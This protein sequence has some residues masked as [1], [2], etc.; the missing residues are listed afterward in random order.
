MI[1][2]VF[3]MLTDPISSPVMSVKLG[4]DRDFTRFLHDPT[5]PHKVTVCIGEEQLN[6]SGVVLAQQSSVLERK[7]REDNGVLMFEEFLDVP[8][9]CTVSLFRCI[10]Y[11]HGADLEFDVETLAVV[12]KFASLYEVEDLFEQSLIWLANHLNAT[13]SVRSALHSLRIA[14][15]LSGERS[16]RIERI[17][18]QFIKLN[19][20]LFEDGFEDLLE[21]KITGDGMILIAN[22]KPNNIGSLLMKWIALSNEN[23]T[24]IMENLSKVNFTEIFSSAEDFSLFVALLS[25][26]AKSADSIK[27]LIDLQKSFF[28]CQ[29]SNQKQQEKEASDNEKGSETYFDK[30]EDDDYVDDDYEEG[31][32]DEDDYEEYDDEEYDYDED[33]YEEEDYDDDVYDGEAYDEQDYDEEAYDQQ[34]YGYDEEDYENGEDDYDQEEYDKEAEIH[35]VEEELDCVEQRSSGHQINEFKDKES[36]KINSEELSKLM[37]SSLKEFFDQ[38]PDVGIACP[39]FDVTR[40]YEPVANPVTVVSRPSSRVS[41]S[42]RGN[43]NTRGRGRLKRRRGSSNEQG[44]RGGSSCME[45]GRSRGSGTGKESVSGRGRGSGNE[46]GRGR[47][48]SKEGSRGRGSGK[49]SGRGRGSSKEGSRGRGSGKESGRGRGSGTEG[50]RGSGKEGSR[51]RGS[52]KDSGRGRG[53]GK[54]SGRG[55]GS[56]KE[57]GRGRGSGTEGGRGRGSGSGKESGSSPGR[58]T[59]R[60][61]GKDS[62]SSRG[63]GAGRGSSSA[64]GR[65]SSG[66]GRGSS[67]GNNVNRGRGGS[68]GS[69]GSGRGGSSK[70]G[71]GK[72]K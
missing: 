25:A 16:S 43:V 54:E 56:G 38:Q 2:H 3:T 45:G 53:S 12:I 17:V 64:K 11:L 29:P 62:D 4:L 70:S 59:V 48:S 32:Y 65:G 47:G 51:R 37:Q 21:F 55:R 39:R 40:Y 27:A 22:E 9:S 52:G 44:G 23:S 20:Y 5:F 50:G 46:S 34:N 10:E 35:D 41:N 68:G 7:F 33:D 28:T 66:R 72:G 13:K 26:N 71:R 24:F 49:E 67:G 18:S 15:T 19:R 42:E 8:G 36:E 61:T 1:I 30:G 6:C 31:D 14:E 63:R 57:E 69:G 58:G 60:G